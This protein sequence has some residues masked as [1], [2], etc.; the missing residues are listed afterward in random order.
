MEELLRLAG[1]QD[2]VIQKNGT[3]DA[4]KDGHRFIGLYISG[5]DCLSNLDPT[6]VSVTPVSIETIQKKVCKLINNKF[7]WVLEV[8]GKQIH[9]DG[10]YNADYFAKHY[11][12]LGYEVIWDRDKWKRDLE[13]MR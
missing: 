4:T 6:V 8:D 11:T 12:D 7:S 1:F 2:I 10:S 5:Y 13:A 9:F 3:Y